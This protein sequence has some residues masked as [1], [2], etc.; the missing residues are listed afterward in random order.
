MSAAGR[1]T[2]LA[3][4]ELEELGKV[5]DRLLP[6]GSSGPTRLTPPSRPLSAAVAGLVP[7]GR[8]RRRGCGRRRG[9]PGRIGKAEEG[10][11][12]EES[13]GIG[14]AGRGRLETFALSGNF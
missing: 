7:L 14:G 4:R 10:E 8:G 1:R 13:Q 9:S 3:V 5:G 11:R 6:G 2:P 12:G